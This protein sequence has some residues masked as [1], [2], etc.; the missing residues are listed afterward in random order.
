MGKG[1]GKGKKQSVITK[2]EEHG[3]EDKDSDYRQSGM[4]QKSERDEIEEVEEASGNVQDGENM[5]AINSSTEN[6][7]KRKRS[8]LV[9]EKTDPV[10]E[11]N[12]IRTNNLDE[13]SK[14]PAGFRQSRSRRKNKPRRAAEAGVNCSLPSEIFV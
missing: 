12:A 6:K 13:D 8:V 7:R 10:K 1:R 3:S 5:K 14:K 2:R 11:E 4:Q 9:K